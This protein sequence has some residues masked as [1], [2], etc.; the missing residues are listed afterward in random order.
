MPTMPP[1]DGAVGG[2]A[3]LAVIGCDRGGGD[4]HAALAG[5][6][7]RVLAHGVSRQPDHVEA[8][9]QVDHDG[10]GIDRQAV[11]PVLAHGLLG[12]RDAG[13]VDQ[14]HELAQGYRLGHHGLAIGFIADVALQER[15]ADRLGD[16]LT[17]FHL[18]VGNHH[19]GPVGRQHARRAFT[20]ARSAAGDDENLALNVHGY[21]LMR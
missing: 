17:L 20:Q 15:A 8:A 12:R 6:F 9:H 10:L 16:S 18:H 11:R 2:L 1:L 19:G 3:D 21:L 7:G 4:H 13:T 5:G 14:A